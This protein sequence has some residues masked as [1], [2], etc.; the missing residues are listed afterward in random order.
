MLPLWNWWTGEL[1]AMLPAS[2][3]RWLDGDAVATEIAVDA[4]GLSIIT[5]DST[6]SNAAAPRLVTLDALASSPV[7]RELIA[8]GRDRVR[9]V[10]T[11]EQ[12]LVK[13]ITLPLATEENLRE[14]IGFELDRHTPFTTAQAYYDVQVIKRDAQNEKISVLLVVASRSAVAGLLDTLQRARLTCNAIGVSGSGPAELK[15]I[16]L[17]PAADKPPRRLSR[18]HRINLALLALAALLA[19]AAVILPIWQ[20][21][22]V[23]KVLFPQAEKSGT[24]FQI[25]ERVYSEYVKLAAEYNFLASKKH[26]VY[27]VV[28]VIEE[29]AKTFGDTTWIQRL[30]IKVNG[31]TREVTMM[32]ETQSS[33]KVIENLEQSPTALFQNS[34]QL[35]AVTRI[36]AN[37]ERFHVS[38][39]IK[40]RPVPQMETIDDEPPPAI[41]GA[42]PM[43]TAASVPATPPG[44][45][46]VTGMGVQV[47]TPAIAPSGP[48]SAATPA[49]TA[50]M[51]QTPASAPAMPTPPPVAKKSG[52]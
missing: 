9:L 8:T 1:K 17:Q 16:D 19:F 39:E 21:R 48:A 52:T 42:P 25:S 3:A 41:V 32:G 22:E 6:N 13:T 47:A 31:K 50:P 27:P 12:A 51:Q 5:R 46:G 11:P 38:A 36:Q 2:I 28:E 18:M 26:V 34:K 4:Q 35:T 30:D 15:A 24:E 20:K 37:T 33:S 14:V 7:F 44:P 10:L 45:G 49:I 43:P 23:V 40:S 29:L